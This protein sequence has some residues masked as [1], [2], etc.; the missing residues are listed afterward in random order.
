MGAF[1]N[2]EDRPKNQPPWP[3]INMQNIGE[4][5]A[6]GE[7]IKV[8]C[9]APQGLYYNFLRRRE[10]DIF[11]LYPVWVTET[12][13]RTGKA[14]K[15]NGEIKKRLVTAKEQFS[16]ENMELVDEDVPEVVTTAQQ[17]LNK[18]SDELRVKK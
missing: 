16:E 15:E 4:N 12:D 17:A 5:R 3:V 18:K 13:K 2:E 10:G 14:L 6:P 1:V 7:S 11:M 8:R 9:I